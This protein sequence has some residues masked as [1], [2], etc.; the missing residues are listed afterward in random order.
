MITVGYRRGVVY[1][2]QH[3]CDSLVT[4]SQDQRRSE[5]YFLFVPHL[6]TFWGTLVANDAENRIY[7]KVV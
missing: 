5:Y 2:P 7:I 3:R 4:H 1:C 6:M